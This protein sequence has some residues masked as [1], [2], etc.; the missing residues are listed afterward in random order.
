MRNA[1]G[2]L[3]AAIAMF[4][5]VAAA[6]AILSWTDDRGFDDGLPAIL[7]GVG[8]A[9]L[10]ILAIACVLL[11]KLSHSVRRARR[12]DQHVADWQVD[13]AL[14]QAFIARDE[15]RAAEMPHM[16]RVYKPWTSGSPGG[17]TVLAAKAGMLVDD[18]FLSMEPRGLGAMTGLQWLPGKPE[19][20]EV[21]NRVPRGTPNN[22]MST[23]PG[24]FRVPV[25]PAAREE[26]IKAFNYYRELCSVGDLSD[27]RG[28]RIMV[29][30]CWGLAALLL[31][32]GAI[33]FWMNANGVM[34]GHIVVPL[35]A[36]IGTMGGGGAALVGLVVWAVMLRK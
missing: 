10:V 26:A 22:S 33:G 32:I 34:S 11:A 19:C 35:M 12:P 31:P 5:V 1:D 6:V 8:V 14:W 21:T 27:P 2:K 36:L 20:I 16:V 24:M 3:R 23:V 4:V 29:R 30:I 13:A 9:A 25:V 17:V 18:I 7:M 28:H 15:T